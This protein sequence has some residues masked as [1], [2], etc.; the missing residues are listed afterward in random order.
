MEVAELVQVV[1]SR[2]DSLESEVTQLREQV[3]Q[4]LR[5]QG[6]AAWL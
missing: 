4:L 2:Q 6:A 5:R 3:Q 1:V